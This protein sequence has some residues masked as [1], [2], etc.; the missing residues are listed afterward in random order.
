MGQLFSGGG[1]TTPNSA[2]M[3]PAGVP[4]FIGSPQQVLSRANAGLPSTADIMGTDVLHPQNNAGATQNLPKI[5]TPSFLQGE[6]TGPAGMPNAT[7]PGL[8]KLGKLAVLL[9]GGVQGALAGRAAQEQT[10]AATGGRRA[11]GVGTGF[12]A[13]YDLPFLRAQQQQ[14]VQMGQ[15]QTQIAQSQ[16]KL[17]PQIAALGAGKTLSEIQKNNA[18][19][20]KAGAEAGA[21]PTKTALEQAQTEAA[22]YKDDPN[23]GLIDLRTGNPVTGGAGLAPLTAEEAS[24]LGKQPGQQV[25]L[26]L[27]NT[28]N[29]IMNRG[30]RSVQANGRSLLVDNQGNTVK[31]MGAATPLVV[32]QNQLGAAGNP[33]SPEFQATVDAVGQGHMDLQTAVGRMGRFPGASFALMGAIEQKYPNYFQG[34]Y[35]A[36]KKVLD[37]FTSRSYSQNLNAISTARE[38]MKTFTDLAKDLDNG[39]VRSFNALGNALGVQFGSDK[40]TNFNIA[41]QFF[42]GEVGKAV[43]AGGG[44]AGERDEL[45]DSISNSSSWKQLSGA[46]STADKLLSGKQTALKNTFSS[47]MNAKPNFGGGN[48]GGNRPPLSSFEH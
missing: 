3:S 24:V 46:L 1:L 37:S 20:G 35:D 44:T 32:M 7:S 8:S 29:E 34:N 33:N 25:P 27:K 40:V 31:D 41:K 22:Y 21:I 2:L 38:H 6:S 11:G 16:A 36:A 9:S 4:S 19:A 10:I 17:Y 45:A 13:G 47:G 43:V 15:A 14:Q 26:K 12:Q 42:S 48:T 39:H 18:E 28:A 30:I 23:L 5:G